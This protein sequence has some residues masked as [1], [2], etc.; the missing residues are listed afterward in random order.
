MVENLGRTAQLNSSANAAMFSGKLYCGVCGEPYRRY[1]EHSGQSGE[2]VRWKCKRYIWKNR[3]CCRNTFLTDGQIKKAF[4]EIINQVIAAPA[5]LE[6]RDPTKT[7]AA[8][9]TC[10]RLTR[11][12]QEAIETG[13]YSANK[14]KALLFDRAAEQYRSAK[15]DDWQYRTDKLKAVL[16]DR[17][18][19]ITFDEN[20]F[21]ATIKK[22]VVYE[23]GRLRFYLHNDLQIETGITEKEK[24][25]DT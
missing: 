4:I 25:A 17:T 10:E 24:E 9:P 23:D 8:S 2:T 15:I 16:G 18:D 14:I 3:V 12:I 11:Q 7:P 19:P 21:I 20:I 13:R 6:R 22:A 1:M 5:M